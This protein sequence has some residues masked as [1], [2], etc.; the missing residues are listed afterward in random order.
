MCL[1]FNLWSTVTATFAYTALSASCASGVL[2][3]C[4]IMCLAK[5]LDNLGTCLRIYTS[6]NGLSLHCLVFDQNTL[7]TILFISKLTR[8]VHMCCVDPWYTLVK[9]TG[10]VCTSPVFLT[11]LFSWFLS[12]SFQ[13]AS[14][15]IY[16]NGFKLNMGT[17]VYA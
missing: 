13:K 8:N 17:C 5:I 1:V 4:Y 12:K 11:H 16:L 15:R 7:H 14:V 10:K 3:H 6:C 2:Q 9:E